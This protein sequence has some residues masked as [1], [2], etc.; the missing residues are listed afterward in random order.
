[1]RL[2]WSKSWNYYK[3]LI[4]IAKTIAILNGKITCYP[5]IILLMTL[6]KWYLLWAYC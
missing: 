1:M 2:N 6:D 4:K 5:K 3:I